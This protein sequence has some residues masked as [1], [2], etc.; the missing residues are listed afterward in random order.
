MQNRFN[1]IDEPWIPVVDHGRVSLRQLFS[2][3]EYRSLGGNPV[4]KIALLKLLLAI[5]QAAATP[6]DEAE[7][8][9]LGADGLA[10]R[11]LAYLDKWHDRF[12]LYG[13]KPFL[14]MPTVEKLVAN[15]TLSKTNSAKTNSQAREAEMDGLPKRFGTGVYPDLPSSNNT[16]LS[17]TLIERDLDDEEKAIFLV[18]IMNFAFGGK[19]V[20]ADMVSLGGKEMGN[21]YSAPAGPSS[22]GWTGYLHAFITT[23]SVVSDVWINLLSET[24]IDKA[25]MWESGVGIPIWEAGISSESCEVAESYKS[26]YMAT[27]IAMSRFVFLKS[28]GI[29]YV[30]G[31]NYR[32]VRDGWFEPSL[33]LNRSGGDIKVRYADPDKRPWREL[34]GLLSFVGS[35]TGQGF[36]CLALRLGV[37]SARDHFSRFAV[38]SSGLKMSVNSGDQSVKQGDDFVE[39]IVWLD[40]DALGENWI[41][42][43][44]AEMSELDALS[45]VLW[46]KV[47]A[48][49]KSRSEERRVGRVRVEAAGGVAEVY[50]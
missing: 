31:I 21:R 38:W 24:D 41:A 50:S 17:H 3:P 14:Q 34:D 29:Y 4:Q 20:E 26:S 11:C 47:F 15:R 30:D 2:N 42:V 5:A 7:W 9:A 46:G 48:Y 27:L 13:N 22:G 43:L 16:M 18:T 35:T 10:E 6:K 45:S 49:F 25:K 28:D 19:R 1:L 8:R 39:S 33:I 44:K 40:G 23:G 32:S 12:Y 37:E 36:E